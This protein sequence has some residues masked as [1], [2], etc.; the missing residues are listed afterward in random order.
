MKGALALHREIHKKEH[1]ASKLG[2]LERRLQK[3]YDDISN[4]DYFI[5]E[6]GKPNKNAKWIDIH[7]ATTRSRQNTLE[8]DFQKE[9]DDLVDKYKDLTDDVLTD[10]ME[11]E[12]DYLTKLQHA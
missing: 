9:Y 2:Q 7:R 10:A 5:D 11:T 4:R 3:F 6:E 12:L 8:I 1:R